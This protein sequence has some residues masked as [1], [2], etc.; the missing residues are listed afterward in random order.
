V[1]LDDQNKAMEIMSRTISSRS[2]SAQGP[3]RAAG[4][5]AQ[6][7]GSSTST[8]S[9]REGDARVRLP[10]AHRSGAPASEANRGAAQARTRLPQREG[11]SR[12]PARRLP[13]DARDHA[14]NV[15]RYLAAAREQIARTRRSCPASS[16]N[17]GAPAGRGAQAPDELTQQERLLRVRGISERNIE[18]MANAG[19]R[20]WR[21]S[22]T[23][24]TW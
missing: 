23:S 16:R 11:T 19:N 14:D 13:A 15:E 3:E 7:A 20:R 10:V 21:T 6:P 5:P 2:P 17:G 24:P 8:A 1:L 18:Q 9:R 22:T 12:T 4:R